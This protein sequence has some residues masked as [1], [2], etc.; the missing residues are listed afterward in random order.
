MPLA[1]TCDYKV[2]LR[3]D[4]AR[5]MGK[6]DPAEEL[7]LSLLVAILVGLQLDHCLHL[8]GEGG[9]VILPELGMRRHGGLLGVWRH[10]ER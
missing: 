10:I 8:R 6:E 5:D 9:S 7:S 1:Y 4:H 2:K 3:V